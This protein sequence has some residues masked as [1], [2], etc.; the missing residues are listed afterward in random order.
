MSESGKKRLFFILIAVLIVLAAGISTALILTEQQS[1]S[2]GV[3]VSGV[4]VPEGQLLVHDIYNGDRLIPEFDVPENTYDMDKYHEDENGIIT[5]SHLDAALGVDVSEHQGDIDWTQVKDAG[6]EFA[7]LRIGYRGSTEGQIYEDTKFQQN[8]DNATA[9]GLKVGVYFFSQA[10][11][12]AEAEAEADFV[13]ETLGDRKLDYPVVYDW[14]VPLASD[15]LPASDL[16]AFDVTGEQVTDFTLAFCD[17]IKENGRT[18]MV[19]FNKSMAY[20]MLDLTRLNQL[21][22]WYAEYQKRPSLY[23]TFRIWQYTDSGNIPGIGNVD[24]N[25]CYE[26]Y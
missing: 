20:E 22:F 21:D 3:T 17:R 12:E 5:Y 18:P 14:E 9:A 15:E 7:F 1:S 8:Y 13:L 19:Y 25:I 10:I 26:I 16:R 4:S 6:V 23:Y 2:Q 24:L 11:S